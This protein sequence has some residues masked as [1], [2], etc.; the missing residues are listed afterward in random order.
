MRGSPRVSTPDLIEQAR[1]QLSATAARAAPSTPPRDLTVLR[2]VPASVPTTPEPSLSAQDTAD[3]AAMRELAMAA[4]TEMKQRRAL[5]LERSLQLNNALTRAATRSAQMLHED[6]VSQRLAEA[7]RQVDAMSAEFARREAEHRAASAELARRYPASPPQPGTPP[8]APPTTHAA[9]FGTPS[10]LLLGNDGDEHKAATTGTSVWEESP[11]RAT[12][13]SL[14]ARLAR[15]EADNIEL[16]SEAADQ[17]AQASL[18]VSAVRRQLEEQQHAQHALVDRL[19][20]VEAAKPRGSAPP[21]AAAAAGDVLPPALEARLA[22]LE[23][24]EQTQHDV[25]R[26]MRDAVRGPIAQHATQLAEMRERFAQQKQWNTATAAQNTELHDSAQAVHTEAE[27]KMAAL[28]QAQ[29]A[30]DAALA[31]LRAETAAA[32]A[33]AAATALTER[34]PAQPPPPSQLARQLERDV[35]AERVARARLARAHDELGARLNALEQRD[36]AGASALTA[37][38]CTMAEGFDAAATGSREVEQLAHS[39]ATMDARAAAAADAAAAKAAALDAQLAEVY[40]S[41]AAQA[42]AARE[43]A[44]A[45]GVALERTSARVESAARTELRERADA[46]EANVAT[47][48]AALR[49]ASAEQ[50]SQIGALRH[51]VTAA[52]SAAE[53]AAG[54]NTA[55][56]AAATV[57]RERLGAATA[58]LQSAVDLENAEGAHVDASALVDVQAELRSLRARLVA[59]EEQ[60]SAALERADAAAA[61]SAAQINALEQSLASVGTKELRARVSDLERVQVSPAAHDARLEEVTRAIASASGALDRVDAVEQAARDGAQRVALV[62]ARLEAADKLA[63]QHTAL[64]EARAETRFSESVAAVDARMQES[65]SGAARS[66]MEAVDAVQS[67]LH[68][69]RAA[70]DAQSELRIAASDA[71]NGSNVMEALQSELRAL[72]AAFNAK[73]PSSSATDEALQSELGKMSGDTAALQSELRALRAVFDEQSEMRSAASEARDAALTDVTGD[74]IEALQ[75]E[76]RT[77]RAAVGAQS[78]LRSAASEAAAGTHDA[79]QSELQSLRAA[80]DAQS[81]AVAVVPPAADVVGTAREDGASAQLPPADLV[82]KAEANA[83]RIAKLVSAFQKAKGWH[84]QAAQER[85]DLHARIDEN[86]IAAT[87]TSSA[88]VAAASGGDGNNSSGGGGGRWGLGFGGLF[89]SSASNA[90]GAAPSARRETARGR[91]AGIDNGSATEARLTLHEERLQRLSEA[92]RANTSTAAETYLSQE[93]SNVELRERFAER[94]AAVQAKLGELAAAVGVAAAGTARNHGDGDTDDA[95]DA[96]EVTLVAATS[97]RTAELARSLRALEGR[98]SLVTEQLRAAEAANAARFRDLTPVAAMLRGEHDAVPHRADNDAQ[99]LQDSFAAHVDRTDGALVAIRDAHDELA[100]SVRSVLGAASEYVTTD[101]L[102]ALETNLVAQQERL[103]E[104]IVTKNAEQRAQANEWR[105]R[106][107]QRSATDLKLCVARRS[108]PPPPPRFRVAPHA[109]TQRTPYNNTPHP[110]HSLTSVLFPHSSPCRTHRLTDDDEEGRRSARVALNE[111]VA[112]A[113]SN[114]ARIASAE[115]ETF[116]LRRAFEE[117][118]AS[119]ERGRGRVAKAEATLSVVQRQSRETAEQVDALRDE[120]VLAED[121]AHVRRAKLTKAH[122][123]SETALWDSLSRMSCQIADLSFKADSAPETDLF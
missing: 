117:L 94:N 115:S 26:A 93:R 66:A 36:V 104:E 23:A 99:V 11:G 49:L 52:Q 65:V 80:V 46:L 71:A 17:E 86:E 73:Q 51:A 60:R 68:S 88:L 74:A 28:R 1:R 2:D 12:L 90:S 24:S 27:Q 83:V 67:E 37:L 89:D 35:E 120:V 121:A 82:A 30:G 111:V 101:A 69:L 5:Q 95:V 116:T 84:K 18:F 107:L 57:E 8:G 92:L 44:A 32:N 20:A 103:H 14:H 43:Q 110:T 97:P 100:R 102:V 112:R 81:E 105:A 56:L 54:A 106:V 61:G 77:L 47:Q 76:L 55:K 59:A 29:K 78:E 38:R 31:E 33:A 109:C 53:L 108:P 10:R 25:R 45:L 91:G 70:V 96:V 39:L 113:R 79:I 41:S 40:R 16:R 21:G 4:G 19:V 48:L 3:L 6:P 50:S 22:A 118:A 42:S 9:S 114:D 63:Q 15:L 87:D 64:V 58:T 7:E 122:D 123:A 13:H 34:T 119:S 85:T 75:L 72:R 62:E 98:L